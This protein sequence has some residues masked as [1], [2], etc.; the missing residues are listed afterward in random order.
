MSTEADK[1][2]GKLKPGKYAG[3]DTARVESLDI[4]NKR[5]AKPIKTTT[6]RLK[7]LR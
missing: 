4:N 6:Q 2:T 1:K 7:R 3:R 5:E